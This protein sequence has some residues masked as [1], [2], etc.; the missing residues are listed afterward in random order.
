MLGAFRLVVA[1]ELTLAFR[2]WS[3]I[4]LPI[5]FFI[6]VCMLFPLAMG[7]SPALLREAGPGAIWVAALLATLLSLNNLFREDFDEGSLE[8]LALSPE[9]LSI[10]L[11]AKT[12]AHWAFKTASSPSTHK[13]TYFGAFVPQCTEN[14]LKSLFITRFR[15]H[16]INRIYELSGASWH[17]ELT[18][19]QITL[20]HSQRAIA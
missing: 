1:R 4:A 2:R 6:I 12:V 14:R 8:Q 7:Q 5:M 9:P 11:L 13:A 19:P 16:H 20:N 15:I 10:L 3:D 17:P 18:T